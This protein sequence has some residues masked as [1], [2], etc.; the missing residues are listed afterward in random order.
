MLPD[1]T[2]ADAKVGRDRPVKMAARYITRDEATAA[3]L[4]IGAAFGIAGVVVL[5]LIASST[6]RTEQPPPVVATTQE[7]GTP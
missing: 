3:A 6:N 4:V 7:V 5:A 2:I 1:R